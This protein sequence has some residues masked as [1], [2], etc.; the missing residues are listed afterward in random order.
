[1]LH[2]LKGLHAF[3]TSAAFTANPKS[4]M[5]FALSVL[6]LNLLPFLHFSIILLY[7]LRYLQVDIFSILLVFALSIS[8]FGFD[9][10]FHAILI[11]GSN[12]LY[13][14]SEFESVISF[15]DSMRRKF[16][17]H[18]LQFLIPGLL[19]VLVPLGML[20]FEFDKLSG[21]LVISGSILGTVVVWHR[22]RSASMRKIDGRSKV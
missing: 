14:S 4:L 21:L 5:R 7:L 18:Y 17:S 6:F 19:Y 20:L 10:I 9:K 22:W 13:T 8:I 1:M 2:T 3:D 16:A 11:R 12:R 15:S